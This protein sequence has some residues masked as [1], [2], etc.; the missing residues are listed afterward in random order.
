MKNEE[1]LKEFT[2][3][4]AGIGLSFLFDQ[5]LPEFEDNNIDYEFIADIRP[6][7]KL[8]VH[9]DGFP[10]RSMG[11]KIFSSGSAWSL[12]RDQ[13]KYV[14]QDSSFDSDSPP[15]QLVILE[16]D[17]KS[18]DIYINYKLF[19]NLLPDPLGFPLNQILMML[20]LSRC[21]G[22]MLHACGIDDSSYG[23]LFLGN[24]GHGKSTI[25]RLW[26]ENQA[27][28]LNDDRIIVRE[29]NSGLLMYGT[30]WH[31][32][33]KEVSPK[34]VPIRKLFFLRH[35]EKN[36]V[37]PKNNAEAVLMLLTRCF[38][39]IWDKE[40]MEYTM[41]LCHHI[42]HKIPCYEFSFKPD[43]KMVDFVRNI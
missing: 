18:G 43:R 37:V 40:G 16:S 6:E 8:R 7:T 9:H 13:G 27:K 38:P 15:N 23:Y 5:N 4:V 11:K 29:K 33:F 12:Y 2:I 20:L 25:A 41:D 36:S 17:L 34:G 30:P 32:D 31:G 39:P 22:V 26:S 19:K 42:V 28:V 10:E 24:S 3:E 1:R 21:K 14:L 35:G